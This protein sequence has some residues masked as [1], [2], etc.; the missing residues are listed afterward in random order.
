[1]RTNRISIRVL[2]VA[3][4][5]FA[6]LAGASLAQA[7]APAS[8]TPKGEAFVIGTDTPLAAVAS[9]SVQIADIEAVDTSTGVSVHLLS[10][11]ATIDFARFDGLQTLIDI[12]SVPVGSYNQIV[13]TIGPNPSLGYLVTSTG[14][15]PAIQYITPTL[16]T[17][18]ITRNLLHPLMVNQSEPVGIRMDFDL[19]QSIQVLN[20]Q[21]T[22]T[23]DPVFNVRVVGPNAPGAFIDEFDTGVLN[24]DATNQSFTVQGPHGRSWTIDT[25]SQTEW[26]GGATFSELNSNTIV[27]ISGVL[28]RATSTITADEITILS[29]NG[30]YAGGLSTFVTPSTGAASSFDLYVRGLLP[31][32]TGVKRGE[33]ATVQLNGTEKYFIR[34]NRHRLPASLTNLVFNADALL[35]GQSIGVGGPATGAASESDVTVK[36]VTL[37]DFGYV[38]KVVDG[39]VHPVK[40]TFQMKVDGFAGQLVPQTVDVYLTGWSRFRF[41]FTGIREIRGGDRVRVVG[42]LIKNPANGN[43]ILLGRYV[44]A[45]D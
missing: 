22:G 16:T 41:G 34:W 1:M 10:S 9:F 23:V 24:V 2:L 11:P 3:L 26:D 45:L 18:T 36:R 4:A 29:Q 44:D 31:A 28:S 42:L 14:N 21:I 30:F 35:P 15:P 20:G 8:A 38:G 32:N 25:T 43:T 19:R 27:Q 40:E 12:N 6:F 17:S 13:I 33:I 7:A 37:R 39:S 5:A